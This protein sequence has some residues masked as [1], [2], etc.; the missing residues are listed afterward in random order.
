MACDQIPLITVCMYDYLH[1]GFVDLGLIF[2][3][4]GSLQHL[5]SAYQLRRHMQISLLGFV[6]I[7]TYTVSVGLL[8]YVLIQSKFRIMGSDD[9]WQQLEQWDGTSQNGENS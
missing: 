8:Y 7:V 4:F 9:N 6:W 1:T 5:Y 3:T 2:L